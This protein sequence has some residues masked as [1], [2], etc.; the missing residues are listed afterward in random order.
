LIVGT[1]DLGAWQRFMLGSTAEKVVQQAT[2]SVLV[3]H[4]FAAK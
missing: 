3:L 1:R 2:C 4:H